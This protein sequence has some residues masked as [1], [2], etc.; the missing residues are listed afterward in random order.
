[1]IDPTENQGLIYNDE[2]N[3]VADNRYIKILYSDS[4][5]DEMGYALNI[6]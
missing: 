4:D 2:E 5:D 6:S 1:M 3:D